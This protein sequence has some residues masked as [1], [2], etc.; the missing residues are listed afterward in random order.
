MLIIVALLVVF[1]ATIVNELWTA[2]ITHGL[3]LMV[4]VLHAYTERFRWRAGYEHARLE[5]IRSAGA[6]YRMGVGLGDWL[7]V[8]AQRPTP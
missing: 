5:M 6:A 8:E 4:I 7:Y 2:A 3:W 1:V